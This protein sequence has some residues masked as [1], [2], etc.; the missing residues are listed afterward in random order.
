MGDFRNEYLL[1]ITKKNEISQKKNELPY[2]SI[3]HY[4][5]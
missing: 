2:V 5:I 3:Y 1:Y 4:V